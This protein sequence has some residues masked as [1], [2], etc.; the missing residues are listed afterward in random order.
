MKC[1]FHFWKKYFI[2]INLFLILLFNVNLVCSC[3]ESV[4]HKCEMEA[5]AY[6]NKNVFTLGLVFTWYHPTEAQ[7]MTVHQRNDWIMCQVTWQ[8]DS[9]RESRTTHWFPFSNPFY[10]V[11]YND[12]LG[13]PLKIFI[14]SMMYNM[15]EIMIHQLWSSIHSLM[16]FH[17]T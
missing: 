2:K 11:F 17:S 15:L 13:L 14:I 8:V 7:C 6:L 12:Y 5:S 1:I 3:K 10:T 9:Q 4:L 16:A